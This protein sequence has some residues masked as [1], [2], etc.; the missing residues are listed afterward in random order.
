MSHFD[1]LFESHPAII[2][3]IS[4]EAKQDESLWHL[5]DTEKS[6]SLGFR[7]YNG[8]VLR[9]GKQRV[10]VK[11]LRSGSKS[12]SVEVA[13]GESPENLM[14]MANNNY[15][16]NQIGSYQERLVVNVEEQ[17]ENSVNE[18]Q[19]LDKKCWICL[20]G[21]SINKPF[22]KNICK[23]TGNMTRH[24]DCLIE[25]LSKKCERSKMGFITFYDFSRM[26]CDICKDQFPSVIQYKDKK[27]M[28]IDFDPSKI[29]HPFM[30]LNVYKID[31]NTLKGVAVVEFKKGGTDQAR[32]VNK[33]PNIITYG[34][35][36]KNDINFKGEL[37][38]ISLYLETTVNLNSEEIVSM[39]KIK[40]PNSEV[41]SFSNKP[42]QCNY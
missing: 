27:K 31:D 14:L 20:E 41:L 39:S 5:I 9:F 40:D 16:S 15:Y 38:K 33:N 2:L 12:K 8:A 37:N 32:R 35:N 11:M 25:W 28:F 34:R 42:F 30:V 36:E 18:S 6:G 4:S 10:E 17:P 3:N 21:E 19:D 13:N 29:N 23:C 22:A 7:L 26:V 1:S 24:V